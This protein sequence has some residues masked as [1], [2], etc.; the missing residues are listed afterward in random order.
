MCFLP[1]YTARVW[2]MNSGKITDA[3]DQVLTTFFSLR[4]FMAS[5]RP[6]SRAST[7]GPFL[8]DRD[9]SPCL[10]L[11]PPPRP[12]DQPVGRLRPARPVAHRWFAPRGLRGHPGR[13]LALTA[14]VGMVAWG[15][16]HAAGL[17]ATAHVAGSAGVAEALVFV[18]DVAELAGPR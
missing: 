12:D 6:M 2:P 10:P 17:R 9:M 5:M 14:A 18:V 13:R 11:L 15:H 16:R 8:T 3:R 7:K 4:L 1:L